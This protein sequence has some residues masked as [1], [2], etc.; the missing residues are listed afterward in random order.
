ML[1]LQ[2]YRLWKDD[3]VN[4]RLIKGTKKEWTRLTALICAAVDLYQ[5]ALH[6]F[7]LYIF[8]HNEC[9][10][11]VPYIHVFIYTVWPTPT[12]TLT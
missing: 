6:G 5:T 3:S 11:S 1:V 7:G 4:M 12:P 8:V 9:E 2:S 10:C